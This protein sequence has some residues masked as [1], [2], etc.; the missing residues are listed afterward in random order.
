MTVNWKRVL[1]ALGLVAG[2]GLMV[3][4]DLATLAPAGSIAARVIAAAVLICT[5]LQR[6]VGKL[7]PVVVEAPK[8]MDATP[9][10]PPAA[11]VVLLW[12]AA[13][14]VGVPGCAWWQKNGKA[15]ECAGLTTIEN[16]PQL[17]NIVSACATVA[18][19]VEAII[20]CV[21]AA[22]NSRWAA[23]VVACFAADQAG[24]V[25]CSAAQHGAATSYLSA[26]NRA[27]LRAAVDQQG[28]S[29]AR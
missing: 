13:V 17:V 28:W 11:A 20:P 1:H 27:R 14:N 8:V 23:D 16:A 18:V 22:A 4:P 5:N 3:L 7:D 15:I 26:D 25:R 10:G 12:L 2:V 19:T 29:F 9:K 24:M 21:Q 6:I